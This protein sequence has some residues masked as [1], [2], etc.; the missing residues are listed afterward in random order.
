MYIFR[1]ILCL[2]ETLVIP[3]Q[4]MCRYAIIQSLWVFLQIYVHVNDFIEIS[5]L[6]SP[7]INAVQSIIV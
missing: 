6:C 5:L 3:F 2:I 1:E 4:Y 7:Q